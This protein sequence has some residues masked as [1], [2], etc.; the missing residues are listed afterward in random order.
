MIRKGVF[1]LE[2]VFVGVT[3][4]DR[5]A[6]IRRIVDLEPVASFYAT[7]LYKEGAFA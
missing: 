6:G 1:T 2:T 4:E 7:A 5:R 3:E